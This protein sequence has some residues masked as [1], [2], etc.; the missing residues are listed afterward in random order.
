MDCS[1]ST[2]EATAAAATGRAHEGHGGPLFR[3]LTWPY[4]YA[5]LPAPPSCPSLWPVRFDVVFFKAVFTEAPY[6][7]LFC[8]A[9]VPEKWLRRPNM[10]APPRSPPW[11]RKG[12]EPI[13]E[14]N[15]APIP[16]LATR[17]PVPRPRGATRYQTPRP[18]RFSD[19]SFVP[20]D[21]SN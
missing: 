13:G 8:S 4:V 14:G 7:R 10:A 12:S 20:F 18:F 11:T 15:R 3:T 21:S 1:F 5:T 9:C 17:G 19:A 6:T 16:S 2:M